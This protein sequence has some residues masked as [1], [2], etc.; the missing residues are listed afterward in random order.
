[1]DYGAFNRYFDSAVAKVLS[2]VDVLGNRSH[3]HEFNG[4]APLRKV[5]GDDDIQKMPT[6][7]IYLSDG[8]EP[9]YDHGFTTWYDARRKHPTRTEYRLYYNDNAAIG[10][11]ETGDL[12]VIA[13]SDDRGL[14]VLFAQKASTI[15]SQIRWLFGLNDDEQNGFVLSTAEANRITSTAAQILDLIGVEVD[16]PVAAEQ[17]LDEMVELFKDTFPKGKVFSQ[18]AMETLGELDWHGDPDGCLLAYYEREEMLFR[19]FERHLLERDLALCLAG[20]NLDVDKVL[21]TTM[22]AFQRRKSRA[23]TAFETQIAAL[24]DA[25]GI[26][27]SAQARTEGKSKPDF[28]FPSID[29]Y[30]DSNFASEGLTMLGAKT[31]IKERWRQ[32]LDEADR[33]P[34]KHLITLEPAVSSDYTAAME[35]DSLQLVVPQPLFSTYTADQRNWLMNVESFCELVEYKQEKKLV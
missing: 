9:I 5:F 35:K 18:H 20:G 22:S 12:M 24:F 31:T 6:T 16:V 34:R 29:A 25:R 30:R 2:R 27:Y 26:E 1:M 4:T 11:A 28:I 10:S 7:F 15:E 17:Y 8:S 33:I 32:V 14:L 3:Q 21:S 19:V 23:G 13:L